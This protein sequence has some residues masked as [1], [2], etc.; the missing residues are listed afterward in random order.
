MNEL[1]D[2]ILSTIERNRYNRGRKIAWDQIALL[3]ID[4]QRFFLDESSHAFIP[5]A[6]LIVNNILSLQNLFIDRGIPVIQTR[7]INNE[8]NAKGMSRWWSDLLVEGPDSEIIGE[9]RNKNVE[10]LKKS[11]YDAFLYTDLEKC[12]VLSG[13]KQI[14]ICGVMTH[15]C[16]ESTS[17]GAFMR[18]FEPFVLVDATATYNDQFQASSHLALAHGFAH[19]VKTNEIIESSEE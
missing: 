9:L 11:Q 4:M 6:P 3:V 1:H 2:K 7:H 19:I 14:V 17:R 5:G 15:L 16:V 8:E 13:I 12:L 10:I 18:G